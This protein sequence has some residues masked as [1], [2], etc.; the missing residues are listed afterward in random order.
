MFDGPEEIVT[1]QCKKHLIGQVIDQFGEN[2]QIS[3]T[4]DDMLD[5]TVTVHLSPTF[6][7]WL[8]QYAGEMTVIGP[9][10]VIEMYKQKMQMSINDMLNN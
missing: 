1:L 3:K 6:F 4:K 7:G 10:H 8:F 2:N 5:I 9:D